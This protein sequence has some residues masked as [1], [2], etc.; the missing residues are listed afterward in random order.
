MSS[1][2]NRI[3]EKALRHGKVK[4]LPA[5][6][7]KAKADEVSEG[8][9]L[10]TRDGPEGILVS[11]P[12]LSFF[13]LLQRPHSHGRGLFLLSGKNCNTIHTYKNVLLSGGL[14]N[15]SSS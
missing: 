13:P 3:F 12:G 6:S 5:R 14:Y 2:D 10:G 11:P 9:T 15:E 1:V 7:A 8:K 4:L